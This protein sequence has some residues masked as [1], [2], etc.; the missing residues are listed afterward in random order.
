MLPPDHPVETLRSTTAWLISILIRADACPRR[1]RMLCTL[2]LEP[3][4]HDEDDE[5]LADPR[6]VM[7]KRERMIVV[8]SSRHADRHF[9]F[10][11]TLFREH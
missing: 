1:R 2:T 10:W 5:M 8:P 11:V 4:E 6:D 7:Q 9:H 3:D